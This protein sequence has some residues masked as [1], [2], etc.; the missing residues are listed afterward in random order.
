MNV[1][2]APTA[3]CWCSWRVYA[4]GGHFHFSGLDSLRFRAS[5]LSSSSSLGVFKVCCDWNSLGTY[6]LL[7]IVFL[8]RFDICLINHRMM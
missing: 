7:K 8:Q 4:E 2:G 5:F 1:T 3:E 6:S